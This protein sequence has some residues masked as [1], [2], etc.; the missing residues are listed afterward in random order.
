MLFTVCIA[1]SHSFCL[2]LHFEFGV[3]DFLSP[4]PLSRSENSSLWISLFGSDQLLQFTLLPLEHIR[5]RSVPHTQ[6]QQTI[7]NDVRV[8]DSALHARLAASSCCLLQCVRLR[9]LCSKFPQP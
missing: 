6:T 2:R 9:G 7:D 4:E 5:K 8:R 3:S 1:L